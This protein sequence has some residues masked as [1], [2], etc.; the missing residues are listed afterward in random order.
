VY[1]IEYMVEAELG[2]W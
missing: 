1:G 2:I